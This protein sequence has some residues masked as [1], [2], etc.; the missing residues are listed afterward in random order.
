MLALIKA[1]VHRRLF[2]VLSVIGLLGV[3]SIID[4]KFIDR[5]WTIPDGT[6]VSEEAD[7]SARG[8]VVLLQAQMQMFLDYPMA[9]DTAAP[10]RSARAISTSGGL[11]G[12]LSVRRVRARRTHVHVDA[13]RAGHFGGCFVLLA[14][15]VDMLAMHQTIQIDEHG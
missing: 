11:V 3:A 7:T 13:R 8:R 10:R 15:A 6:S 5:M 2:W 1:K 14:D 4:Q 9:P 12:H